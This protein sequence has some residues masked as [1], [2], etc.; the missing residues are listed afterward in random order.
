MRRLHRF[1][2]HGGYASMEVTNKRGAIHNAMFETTDIIV[3][4]LLFISLFFEVFVLVTFVEHAGKLR[5]NRTMSG[6]LPSTTIIV[7][8]YNEERTVEKTIESLLALEYPKEKLTVFAVD[9]GS[10]DGTWEAL[11]VYENHP[12]VRIFH[13]ENG[14]KHTA[15]NLGLEYVTSDIVGCLDADSWVDSQAL[16]EMA[17]V[18]DDP[19]VMA[20]TPAIK[21]HDPKSVIQY[22]QKAEYAVSAFVRRTFSWMD[23][24]FITPGPFSLFRRS[25]FDELG[26]YRAAH[27]TEDMEIAM[28]MQSVHMKIENAPSAH[29]YTNAPKTYRSLFRQRYRWTYGFIKNT[30]DYRHMMFNPRYGHLGMF[31]LPLGFFTIFPAIYFTALLMVVSTQ[32][33]YAEYERV[34]IVGLSM[35]SVEFHWFYLNTESVTILTAVILL[36]MLSIIYIGKKLM[37]EDKMWTRDVFMYLFLYGFLAPWW[38][39]RA[40]VAVL[41]SSKLSWAQEIDK[42]RAAE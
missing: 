6:D 19:Q 31:I 32:E 7:P 26:P 37:S 1:L 29:V 17:L 9:D 5:R 20:V 36:I 35:P 27:N 8:C 25:V 22:I 40:I 4:I 39:A 15:L 38:L 30:R 12:Q 23:S 2:P 11:K 34:S 24:L 14:G 41:M 18:F 21:I 10:K 28:R 13:K 3:H 16:K 42:R 33:L